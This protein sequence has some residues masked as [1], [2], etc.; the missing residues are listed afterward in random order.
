ML[1]TQPNTADET[2]SEAHEESDASDDS[3]DVA[4]VRYGTHFN[5]GDTGFEPVTSAV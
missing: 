1:S 3:H 2:R 5:V 4:S